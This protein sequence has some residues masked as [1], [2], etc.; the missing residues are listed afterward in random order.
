[1][2][3]EPK[4]SRPDFRTL[5]ESV[6]AA[7][8]TEA[9]EVV[10]HELAAIMGAR[11]VSFLIADFSG[12]AVVRFGRAE[13][14]SDTA[15]PEGGRDLE[16]LQLSDTVYEQVLRT[17]KV[18]VQEIDG[19]T[20]LT[21][22]VTD[23]GDAIGVLELILTQRP[24]DQTV[25]DVAAAA[26]ALAYVVVAN[27]RHT[28]LFEWGQRT[29]PFSLAAEI[30][31]RLL[32]ASFTCEAGQFTI[33]GWLEPANSVGGDTF[34]Y[35]LD[36]DALH[37]SI[38]DAAGHDVAAALLATLL[39]G[40][41][42]NGRRRGLDLAEQAMNANEAVVTNTTHG[43]FVTGQLMRIDLNSGSAIIVNAGHP[44]PLRLR[45]GHV[46]EIKLDIDLPFGIRSGNH[47]R[48]NSSPWHPVIAS[49]SSPTACSNATR[50]IWT[51]PTRSALPVTCTPARPFTP[52]AR[53]SCAPREGI[54]ETTPQS[55][56]STGTAARPAGA[57]APEVQASTEHR[58]KPI[59]VPGRVL[60]LSQD[61]CPH[62]RG[63]F[64]R[65]GGL[66]A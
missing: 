3:P 40:S 46:E 6:E 49:S 56:V 51:C 9:I 39:V 7:A 31:R 4:R 61:E 2:L 38:T 37:V 64:R 55:C 30:Q 28:D 15:S 44:L 27:R 16:T 12:N 63:E 54:S 33:A 48:C 24:D 8:P 41:L 66:A 20:Q 45:H 59:T 25:A 29:A 52:S 23:R 10:T 26:H 5:L 60:G 34:D 58:H 13:P 35:N 62:R 53:Q 17:Q 50:P 14:G 21:V 1:M 19:G 43:Q 32:P 65:R 22:P 36:Q 11:A 47:F 42:R 18:D 57:G